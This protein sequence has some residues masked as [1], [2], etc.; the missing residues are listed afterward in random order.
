MESW[1]ELHVTREALAELIGL[2]ED[3]HDGNAV[4]AARGYHLPDRDDAASSFCTDCAV[5]LDED[6]NWQL[7]E[8][9]GGIA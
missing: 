5:R 2:I 3:V 1:K 8:A 7:P 4:C 6:G 9:L